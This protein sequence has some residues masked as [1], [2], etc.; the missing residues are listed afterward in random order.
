MSADDEPTEADKAY[1]ERYKNFKSFLPHFSI[2]LPEG[3][4]PYFDK[5]RLNLRSVR[6]YGTREPIGVYEVVSL[7]HKSDAYVPLED[8]LSTKN[9]LIVFTHDKIIEYP[10]RPYSDDFIKAIMHPVR[11]VPGDYVNQMLLLIHISPISRGQEKDLRAELLKDKTF[12]GIMQVFSAESMLST[13]LVLQPDGMLRRK[14]REDYIRENPSVAAVPVSRPTV[15]WAL[16]PREQPVWRP[17]SSPAPLPPPAAAPA[18]SAFSP[19]SNPPTE[20]MRAAAER[21]RPPQHYQGAPTPEERR[22]SERRARAWL[23]SPPEH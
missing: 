16:P 7:P 6:N 18:G 10:V 8:I 15:Q 20:E 5:V 19:W 4:S 12:E 11:F 21:F 13:H 2:D 17:H 14:T 1:L 9:S 3:F 23:A 22:Q